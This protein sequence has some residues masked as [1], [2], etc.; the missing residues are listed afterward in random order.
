MV[1]QGAHPAA[2]GTEWDPYDLHFGGRRHMGHII[3]SL[4]RAFLRSFLFLWNE[5]GA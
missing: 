3:L 5:Y 4:V 1:F 2:C